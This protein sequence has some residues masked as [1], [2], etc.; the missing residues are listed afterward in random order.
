MHKAVFASQLICDCPHLI[1]SRFDI[2]FN[3]FHSARPGGNS[4][5]LRLIREIKETLVPANTRAGSI[6]GTAALNAITQLPWS[7]DLSC[8]VPE[9]RYNR[10]RT[11]L[12]GGPAFVAV[13]P[14]MSEVG[15][16]SFTEFCNGLR[17]AVLCPSGATCFRPQV[18]AALL[19]PV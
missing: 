18:L 2:E 16:A 12:Q 1:K 7:E 15:Q 17:K 3:G 8:S 4:Q 14:Y 5:I 9:H 13:Q 10:F 11:D 6:R 19:C